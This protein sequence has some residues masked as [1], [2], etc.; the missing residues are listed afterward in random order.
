MPLTEGKVLLKLKGEFVD[1]MCEVNDAYKTTVIYEKGVKFFYLIF[2]WL[3]YGCIIAALLWYDLYT[4]VL[5]DTGFT[6]KSYDNCVA[7]MMIN[8][9]KCTVLWHV[10]DN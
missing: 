1:I 7:N 8:G 6:L 3:I 10:D 4:E 9:S 2:L 5:K